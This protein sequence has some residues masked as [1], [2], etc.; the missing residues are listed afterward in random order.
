M[1]ILLK[2]RDS[3]YSYRSLFIFFFLW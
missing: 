1:T 2:P 3:L